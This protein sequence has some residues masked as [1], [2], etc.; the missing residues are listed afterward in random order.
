VSVATR[1]RLDGPDRLPALV[2]QW[3]EPMWAVASGP[4]GGGIGVRRWV[5]NAQVP[6]R[7]ARCDPDLHLAEIAAGFGLA[8]PGAGMLT[9]ADV[10]APSRGRDDG[11][12][13]LATVGLGYPILA[14]AP[15]EEAPTAPP[16]EAPTAPP[17]EAPA[18]PPEEAPAVPPDQR[19]TRPDETRPAPPG[20]INIVAVLPE[21]LSDAALV[22]AV[23][24]LTEAK[25]QALFDAGLDATGTATDAVCILCPTTGPIA[26]FGGPRSPVGSRLA[27][28]VYAAVLEGARR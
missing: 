7:Y 15:P 17:E 11:V 26:A 20:T 21:R 22:N 23:V 12:E 13:V 28:A 9:A 18:A 6:H 19:M 14:A 10:G 1:F 25:T 16:E 5:V 2:W 27:R 4:L 24:T 3:P 8:G